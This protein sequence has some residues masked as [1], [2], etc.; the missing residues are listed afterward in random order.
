M[1]EAG[2]EGSHTV[3]ERLAALEERL[4]QVDDA[5]V[6][7]VLAVMDVIEE[8]HRQS[9]ERIDR[10]TATVDRLAVLVTQSIENAN[11]D[12]AIIRDNQTEIRRIWEY[13]L[14]QRPNGQ[15]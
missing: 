1:T 12:R 9:N 8:V 15:G 7:R 5:A 4:K 2:N 3:E 10:L 13:L 14:R 6:V 11:A